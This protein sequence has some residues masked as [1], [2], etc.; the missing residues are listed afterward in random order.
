MSVVVVAVVVVVAK[1]WKRKKRMM[2]KKKKKKKKMDDGHFDLFF[3]W[4]SRPAPPRPMRNGRP[5]LA[6]GRSLTET[7]RA[8][9]KTKEEE[10]EEKEEEE[11]EDDDD[12]DDEK[13]EEEGPSTR[14]LCTRCDRVVTES[15]QSTFSLSLSLSVSLSIY[16]RSSI[17]SLSLSLSGLRSRSVR[18]GRNSPSS[19]KESPIPEKKIIVKQQKSDR[20][21]DC[22]SIW[23]TFVNKMKSNFVSRRSVSCF[24]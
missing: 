4:A 10:D 15:I 21:L 24:F 12:D 17:L 8:A 14:V 11:E 6:D 9:T 20:S 1:G 19:A 23:Q 7:S 18:P 3:F 16:L 5:Q 13:E 2:M 22:H